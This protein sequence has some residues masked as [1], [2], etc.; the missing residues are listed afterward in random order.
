MGISDKGHHVISRDGLRI[1]I[2]GIG[3]VHCNLS[4]HEVLLRKVYHVPDLNAQLFSIRIHRRRG[5][6]CFL[7]ADHIVSWLTLPGFI[8]NIDDSENFPLSI[9]PSNS[10]APLAYAEPVFIRKHLKS[11]R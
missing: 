4:G 9:C 2:Q 8:I 10:N 6:G 1:P 3:T 7:V 11:A 5:P